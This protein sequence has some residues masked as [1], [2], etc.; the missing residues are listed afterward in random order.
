MDVPFESSFDTIVVGSGPGG[1]TVAR[2][3]SRRGDRVLIL[4]RGPNR[5]VSGRLPQ[6]MREAMIP[7]RS[8]LLTPKLLAMIRAITAGGSSVYYYA[9]AF[10]PPFGRLARHGV[11][12]SAEVEELKSELP[13]AP[14]ADHLIG[15]AASRIMDSARSL[16]VD[17][18]PLPKLVYQ[19]RCRPDC[20]KCTL[21]C[22][23]GAKWTSR[24]FLDEAV[25]NGAAF[26]DRARVDRVVVE[27]GVATGVDARVNGRRQR[28]HGAR[29]VVAAGG[30]GSPVILRASG[31]T[32]A[33]RDFFFDPLVIVMGVVK[34]LRGGREFPMA[35]GINMAGEGYVLSDLVLPRLLYQ[36]F[37]AEVLRFHRLLDHASVL[38]IMVKIRDSLG[39]R[40]TNSGGV[41]KSLSEFDRDK[42]RRGSH[43]ATSILEK[44]GARGIFSSWRLA[45]HPGG[46]VKIGDIV[47]SDLKTEVDNLYV[48]DASVIP[49]EMGLPPTLTIIGLGKRLSK[50][51][52]ATSAAA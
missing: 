21:G 9:T 3:L 8:L 48:C 46:T 42:L 23:Y 28:F 11:D 49:E 32:R 5:P 24:V 52:A 22:P 26:L 10:D 41:R 27:D 40:L 39:G 20:D 29:V 18:Q 34:E 4:E 33:G 37:T 7:G 50:H 12:I 45:T 6:L 38:P 2:E 51:L 25:G 36:L 43:R 47:D 1:A 14:L 13:Y 35:T 19:D 17:W 44:A 30:I 16:G 31:I 15:P